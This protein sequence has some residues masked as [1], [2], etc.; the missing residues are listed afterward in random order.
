[1]CPAMSY[2]P[3]SSRFSPFPWVAS[4]AWL[5]VPSPLQW[6]WCDRGKTRRTIWEYL[7]G[8]LHCI[9]HCPGPVSRNSN[10][11]CGMQQ[12]QQLTISELTHWR[13]TAEL[14]L[15]GQNCKRRQ[16]FVFEGFSSMVLF[17]GKKKIVDNTKAKPGTKLAIILIVAPI[18]YQPG[19]YCQE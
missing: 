10:T 6:V 15:P 5:P 7:R 9:K 13:R 18:S 19:K 1:M 17:A 2:H 3:L 11:F 14:G 4:N 8:P 12:Q 16:N